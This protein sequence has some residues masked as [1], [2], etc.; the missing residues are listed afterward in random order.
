MRKYYCGTDLDP[1][2]VMAWED[3]K[4][5]KIQFNSIIELKD[6]IKMF[7]DLDDW[8]KTE[9]FMWVTEFN[10]SFEEAIYRASFDNFTLLYPDINDSIEAIVEYLNGEVFVHDHMKTIWNTI[11][12]AFVYHADLN[13]D[14]INFLEKNNIIGEFVNPGDGET[15]YYYK[16]E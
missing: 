5:K 14:F 13:E 1:R 2:F 6:Y 16:G 11:K 7:Y 12:N 10:L 4:I 8:G 3:Q 15:W 9:F